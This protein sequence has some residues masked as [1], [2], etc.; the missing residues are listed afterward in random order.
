MTLILA[1]SIPMIDGME[2]V[3]EDAI[4]MMISILFFTLCARADPAVCGED[5]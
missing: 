1:L 5:S 3:R 2:Q 4:V